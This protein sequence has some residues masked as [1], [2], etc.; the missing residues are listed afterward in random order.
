MKVVDSRLVRS[1]E[2]AFFVVLLTVEVAFVTGG[3]WIWLE[4][5]KTRA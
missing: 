2:V 4:Y 3:W 1:L 5:L